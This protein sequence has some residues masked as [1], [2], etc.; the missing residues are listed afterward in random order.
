MAPFLRLV[1]V[2]KHK[3][4]ALAGVRYKRLSRDS[5]GQMLIWNLRCLW[6]WIITR[7]RRYV[8]QDDTGQC[9]GGT[10]CL[11]FQGVWMHCVWYLAYQTECCYP[12]TTY[13]KWSCQFNLHPCIHHSEMKIVVWFD[14]ARGSFWWSV[15]LLKEWTHWLL[16]LRRFGCEVLLVPV[17]AN[18]WSHC[19]A[20]SMT[21]M[22]EPLL[23]QMGNSS[24]QVGMKCIFFRA[25]KSHSA[26]R[27][28]SCTAEW[29]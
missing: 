3:I 5:E 22:C 28:C 13:A 25:F 17:E 16:A 15:L 12:R 9:S 11:C 14:C 24:L 18:G 10:S 29:T 26:R 27:F 21:M 19:I 8:V 7:T 6:L 4:A 20:G 23:W 2:L 1:L